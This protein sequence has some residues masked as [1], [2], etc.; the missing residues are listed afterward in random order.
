MVSGMKPVTEE[1]AAIVNDFTLKLDA[2]SAEQ[3]FSK[4]LPHKW[5]KAEVT[6]HLI[7]S[8]Q[9]NLR[10]F[11][12]AQYT[13]TPHIVYD[14]EFW[15]NANAYQDMNKADIILLWKLINERICAVL[16]TMPEAAYS[17][18]CNTGKDEESL[19]TVEWLAHDYVKHMKHH[20]NQVLPGSFAI[21][22]P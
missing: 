5:S 1:L 8:A 18:T 16:V 21:T 7:D 10:R 2:V 9:N 12:V 11:I 3:F 22:Y 13:N 20:L 15:V 17:K 4:P 19:H 14:Q 6:G